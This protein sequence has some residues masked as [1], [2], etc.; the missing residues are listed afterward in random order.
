MAVVVAVVAVVAVAAVAAT[1]EET[2]LVSPAAASFTDN[3]AAFSDHSVKALRHAA[4][5]GYTNMELML[6]TS[7][8]T[9]TLN[10]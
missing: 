9:Y 1:V 5:M 6:L 10:L 4:L 2:R 3:L 8:V 7:K